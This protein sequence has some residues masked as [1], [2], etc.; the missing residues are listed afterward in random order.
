M[1]DQPTPE[2][3]AKLADDP[4]PPNDSPDYV[5]AL[6]IHIHLLRA[7]L[8]DERAKKS[9]ALIAAVDDLE[10][11]TAE[12]DAVISLGR[13]A[14]FCV[15]HTDAERIANTVGGNCPICNKAQIQQL[16]AERDS[17]SEALQRNCVQ[18][19]QKQQALIA[20]RD[21][22]IALAKNYAERMKR[23]DAELAEA[24]ALLGLLADI[25]AAV[26]DPTGKLMQDELV[27]R[28]RKLRADN[29]LLRAAKEGA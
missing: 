28:C 17:L 1:T 10:R 26:G 12:R 27:E 16:R 9:D 14:L 24:R 7:E 4:H 21:D 6:E 2:T 3:D 18:Y 23:S 13:H 8:A 11:L 20:E 22:A 25:R 5:R 29:E 19:V 15:H